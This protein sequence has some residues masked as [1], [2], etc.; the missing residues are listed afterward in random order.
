[1]AGYSVVGKIS[2]AR[3]IL[4]SVAIT[5]DKTC[6]ERSSITFGVL[7]FDKGA[8][9]ETELEVSTTGQKKRVCSRGGSGWTSE[10]CCDLAGAT[11]D[12]WRTATSSLL[13][14]PVA[15]CQEGV[16]KEREQEQ[17]RLEKQECSVASPEG[18]VVIED[19]TSAT[20]VHTGRLRL[21]AGRIY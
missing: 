3:A 21:T 17:C 16:E 6:K 18:T 14:G 1:M 19:K 20:G 8:S 4:A 12:A 5:E 2:K 13:P 7:A 9:R 15:L 10:S 11:A